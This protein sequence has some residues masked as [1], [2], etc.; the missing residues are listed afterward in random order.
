MAM[1]DRN[2][3]AFGTARLPGAEEGQNS[4]GSTNLDSIAA[5]KWVMTQAQVA[6]TAADVD[7]LEDL[8]VALLVERLRQHDATKTR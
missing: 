1:L 5:A 7:E 6:L 2:N 3:V 4:N 8:L